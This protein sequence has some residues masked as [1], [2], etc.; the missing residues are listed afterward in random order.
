[1]VTKH[2]PTDCNL[3]LAVT[4]TGSLCKRKS[5]C[6]I[7]C[8]FF[9][10]QHALKHG[11]IYEPHKK[12]SEKLKKCAPKENKNIDINKIKFPCTAQTSVFFN[13][14]DYKEFRDMKEKIFIT[15]EKEKIKNQF[16]GTKP[17]KITKKKKSVVTFV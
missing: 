15:G 9:C 6:K 14:E 2:P 11:G 10:W 4:S 13:K 3:C 8:N 12:C 5:Q 1:M 17:K 7:G 16:I